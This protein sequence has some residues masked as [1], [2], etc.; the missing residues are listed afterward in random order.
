M[1]WSETTPMKERLR[2]WRDYQRGLFESGRRG[3]FR[4]L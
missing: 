4:P 1:P 2:F 3:A